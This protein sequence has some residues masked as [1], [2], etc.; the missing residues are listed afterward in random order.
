MLSTMKLNRKSFDNNLNARIDIANRRQKVVQF[1][2]LCIYANFWCKHTI[3]SKRKWATRNIH[4]K[5]ILIR[6]LLLQSLCFGIGQEKRW[7]WSMLHQSFRF[8]WLRYFNLKTKL[9]LLS[10]TLS[11]SFGWWLLFFF[12]LFFFFVRSFSSY[13]FIISLTMFGLLVIICKINATLFFSIL[14]RVS[15]AFLSIRTMGKGTFDFLR[16]E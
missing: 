1:I 8:Q 2:W 6:F 5:L 11:H 4:S 12:F 3:G 10:L 13:H 9:F 7:H 15:P 16:I 14:L